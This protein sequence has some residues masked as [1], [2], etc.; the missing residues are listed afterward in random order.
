[1]GYLSLGTDGLIGG[2]TICHRRTA[3]SSRIPR[4]DTLF[5]CSY[6][7]LYVEQESAG[8]GT[9]QPGLLEHDKQ[10]LGGHR[11]TAHGQISERQVHDE[12]VHPRRRVGGVARGAGATSAAAVA[13]AARRQPHDDGH[14]ADEGEDHQGDD[15]GDALRDF[16]SPDL[17]VLQALERSSADQLAAVVGGVQ[18]CRRRRHWIFRVH[19]RRYSAENAE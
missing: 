14:V 9:E 7:D 1:M 11:E 8:G 12:H 19:G 10:H 3:I 15:G 17:A 2:E 16:G 4:G 6:T 13:A 5:V 18:L